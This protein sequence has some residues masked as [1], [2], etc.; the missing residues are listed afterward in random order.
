M[1]LLSRLAALPFVHVVASSE[2]PAC[3]GPPPEPR[4]VPAHAPPAACEHL[5]SMLATARAQEEYTS[6]R[7]RGTGFQW[8]CRPTFPIRLSSMRS[9][10]PPMVQSWIARAVLQTL[11]PF[12]SST[13]RR[14]LDFIKMTVAGLG[15]LHRYLSSDLVQSCQRFSFEHLHSSSPRS[16]RRP[17]GRMLRSAKVSSHL[18]FPPMPVSQFRGS[19]SQDRMS[20]TL[21]R[22]RT[23]QYRGLRDSARRQILIVP[24][25]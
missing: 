20:R 6:T 22:S 8:R 19:N 12:I 9:A 7:P 25:N 5:C 14:R 21:L 2:N 11:R 16:S 3:F 18:F 15:L 17:L 13:R 1:F 4:G 23:C 10:S 24:R